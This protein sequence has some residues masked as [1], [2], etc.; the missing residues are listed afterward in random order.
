MRA[1]FILLLFTQIFAHAVSKPPV[2]LRACVN[3]KDSTVTISWTKISD[4]CGSFT[5]M[6]IYGNKDA[7][8]F[9]KIATITDVNQQEY[10]FKVGDPNAKR[11]YYLSIHT[12][13]DGLDSAQ[14]PFRGNA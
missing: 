12:L 11:S 13:C 6:D 5:K 14:S 4:A 8:P 7:S 2:L 10:P 3:K 9:V 1:F